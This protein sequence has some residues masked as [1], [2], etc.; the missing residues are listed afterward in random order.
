M[1]AFRPAAHAETRR[2]ELHRRG[3]EAR[4]GSGLTNAVAY[5]ALQLRAPFGTGRMVARSGLAFAQHAA[6]LVADRRDGSGLAAIHT[7]K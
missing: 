3:I 7:Q 6:R 4:L 5:G 1:L 2:F